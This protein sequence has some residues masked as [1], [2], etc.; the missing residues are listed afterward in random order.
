VKIIQDRADRIHK[1]DISLVE[2]EKNPLHFLQVAG[3]MEKYPVYSPYS[4]SDADAMRM[5]ESW[6]IRAMEAFCKQWLLKK[7]YN[8]KQPEDYY[9]MG[10]SLHDTRIHSVDLVWAGAMSKWCFYLAI[11]EHRWIRVALSAAGE[12]NTW[13]E[14]TII[15]QGDVYDEDLQRL[16]DYE[17]QEMRRMNPR[18]DLILHLGLNHDNYDDMA[19]NYLGIMK[20][21][22]EYVNRTASQSMEQMSEKWA[23]T[24]LSLLTGGNCPL[25]T[26]Y[27]D[28]V[29]RWER[30][31]D[32]IRRA[33]IEWLPT[34]YEQGTENCEFGPTSDWDLESRKNWDEKSQQPREWV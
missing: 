15:F 5:E 4:V 1:E 19:G 6:T 32:A 23:M 21:A 13:V 8:V 14:A 2:G 18:T 26:G 34:G 11:C 33:K 20:T 16:S 27:I 3:S 12:K 7:T 29:D 28:T 10:E 17:L 30:V 31:E 9:S 25:L 24:V 22:L